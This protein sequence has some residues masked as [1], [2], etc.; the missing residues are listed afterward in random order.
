MEEKRWK[1]GELARETGLTVRTLHH[2][3][4]VGL[5]RPSERTQAGYRLYEP[6]DVERLY[7][8]VA[9]RSLGL[10]LEQ[11]RAA[12]AAELALRELIERQLAAVD[13]AI[14]LQAELRRRLER[15]LDEPDHGPMIETIEVMTM[16]DKHYSPE[17]LAELDTLAR[18]LGDEELASAQAEWTDLVEAIERERV[19]GT[20]PADPRVQALLERADAMIEQFTGG[21]PE[22]RASLER[23]YE[24]EGPE[25]ASRG[26]VSRAAFDFMGRARRARAQ[27]GG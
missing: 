25:R 24:E 2:W 1:V 19:A 11:I 9:L 23:M 22:T 12:L 10:T 7:R 16:I 3:D 17:Q 5:V 18:E 14:R 6:A 13:D 26:L 27:D 15:L 4:E 21:D 20:D 8:V